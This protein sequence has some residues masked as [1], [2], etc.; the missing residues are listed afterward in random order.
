MK[1][2]VQYKITPPKLHVSSVEEVILARLKA[3]AQFG[4]DFTS[5]ETARERFCV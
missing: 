1:E 4:F 5:E 2:N 3:K